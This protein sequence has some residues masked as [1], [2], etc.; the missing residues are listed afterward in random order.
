MTPERVMTDP[1]F[2]WSGYLQLHLTS[3]SVVASRF[4]PIFGLRLSQ[5]FLH[6]VSVGL[7]S[8][9][10]GQGIFQIRSGVRSKELQIQYWNADL[11]AYGGRPSGGVANPYTVHG[12]DSEG[13]Q[14][15]GSNH[16]AQPQDPR[17]GVSV[18]YAADIYNAR[19]ADDAA[20][21]PFHQLLPLYG[22]D[23]PLKPGKNP[24]VERW[25]IE[26]H[27]R[28]NARAYPGTQT[29]WPARPGVH[30][31]LMRG[32][33]GGDVTNLQRQMDRLLKLN[34]PER[35]FDDVFGPQTTDWV[36]R[37]CQ[38]LRPNVTRTAATLGV[39][40]EAD[41]VAYEGHVEE[42]TNNPEP[43]KV[44]AQ[45]SVNAARLAKGKAG[46]ALAAATDAVTAAEAVLREVR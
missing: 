26:H 22:L 42:T 1:K 32:M 33:L 16:M 2:D 19:G 13:V 15:S 8:E 44:A 43:A 12:V 11:K 24:I 17:W 39:W 9:T 18:G 10:P 3:P 6:L 41:Q 45:A 7:A 14:R 4:H 35:D 40:A 34:V 28:R 20:W 25:H 23:W 21:A 36:A 37:G 46:D 38:L 27:S 30:R 31:P 5:L 29:C